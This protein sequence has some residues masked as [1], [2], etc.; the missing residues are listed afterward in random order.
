MFSEIS[1]LQT[2]R[3]QKLRCSARERELTT[4]LL[5]DLELVPVIYGWF[6]DILSHRTAV[7]G[8]GSVA[9]RKKFIFIILYLYSPGTLV[10]VKMVGGLRDKISEV[11]NVNSKSTISDNCVNALFMYRN[12]KTFRADIESVYTEIVRRLR[13]KGLLR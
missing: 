12:Y 8:W 3:E 7:P 4:P 6:R 10:G 11:V 9:Q 13:E 2:I 5:T 1:E